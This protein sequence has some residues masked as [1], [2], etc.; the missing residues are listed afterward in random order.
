M[1]T[2]FQ[3]LKK[4]EV[5]KAFK[6]HRITRDKNKNPKYCFYGPKAPRCISTMI[7]FVLIERESLPHV[8]KANNSL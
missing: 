8:I 5:S 7:G 6:W 1:E 2:R 3:Y 4:S